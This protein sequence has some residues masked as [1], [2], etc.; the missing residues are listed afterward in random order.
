MQND[1]SKKANVLAAICCC[2]MLS[3]CG[4]E[5]AAKKATLGALKDPDS[6][7]F[8]AFSQ[9]GDSACLTVNA[10]NSMGGYAGNQEATLEKISGIWE[11]IDLTDIS[12]ESCE[13]SMKSHAEFCEKLNKDI[14]NNRPHLLSEAQNCGLR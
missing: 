1:N 5:S 12:H 3:A 4:D 2:L 9:E 14:V 10:R 8:G 11:V 6:A 7:K 13:S